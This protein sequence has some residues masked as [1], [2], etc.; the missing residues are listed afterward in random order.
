MKLFKY[1]NIVIQLDENGL[2]NY[3][4][5]HLQINNSE[6][7]GI[8][9]GYYSND[10]LKAI[11]TEFCPPSK[12]SI[13]GMASFS[14]GIFGI[15]Q[16]LEEKWRVGQYYLGDWHLHPYSKPSASYQD[17]RQIE[18]NSKDKQLNCPEPIMVIVGGM[19]NNEINVYI[20]I[21][22]EARVCEPFL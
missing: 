7:G 4:E 13:L 3:I 14:R 11:I 15:E 8:I 6:T 10:L 20:F 9:C 5:K 22:G 16:Y 21:D 12:D 17:L 1:K 18:L 19:T 2:I